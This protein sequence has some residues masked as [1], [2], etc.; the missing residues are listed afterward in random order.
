MKPRTK[1]EKRVEELAQTLP[2][3]T[4]EQENKMMKFLNPVGSDWSCVYATLA[5]RCEEFQVFRVFNVVMSHGSSKRS[6]ARCEE[7]T[8]HKVIQVQGECYQIWMNEKGKVAIRA[9]SIAPYPYRVRPAYVWLR[10]NGM[11]IKQDRINNSGE[12]FYMTT[13]WM[14]SDSWHPTFLRNLGGTIPDD[15]DA[16]YICQSV[17]S[18]PLMETLYK[19]NDKSFFQ[20]LM[21]RKDSIKTLAPAIKIALRHKYHPSSISTYIDHLLLLHKLGKDL[22]NPHYVCPENLVEEHRKYYQMYERQQRAERERIEIQRAIARLQE[23]KCRAENYL[24]RITPFL[25]LQWNTEKYSIHV[26]PTVEAMIEEGSAMHHC[27]GACAYDKKADSLILFC[28]TPKGERISTIEYSIS[29]G[30]V[31]QNRAA[32]NKKPQFFEEVNA[33]LESDVERIQSCRYPLF[34][35]QAA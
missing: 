32:C 30:V 18:S 19:A 2:P 33:L 15:Y 9:Y 23:E 27:V 20:Y 14:I 21:R 6:W 24:R 1:L 35:S 17:L 7:D 5:Q 31:L 13:D 26:C 25:S 22:R 12:P 16:R 11:S 29:K 3:L 28:R 8:I 34:K 4:R 10:Y